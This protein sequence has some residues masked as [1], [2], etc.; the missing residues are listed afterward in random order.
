MQTETFPYD[1]ID[2]QERVRNA[3]DVPDDYISDL[4]DSIKRYGLL[5]PILI[6]QHNVLQD[7]WCRFTAWQRLAQED[8]A[9]YSNIP[10]YRRERLT[11][12]EY[13]EVE[14]ETNF[15]RRGFTWQE[16]IKAVKKIH[17]IRYLEAMATG[18]SWTAAMTGELLGG[19][20]KT[21]VNNCLNLAG[22]I[23]SDAY[24]ACD[25]I[26]DAVR[27]WLHQREDLAVAEQARRTQLKQVIVPAITA[28]G[29]VQ[30]QQPVDDLS[31]LMAGDPGELV[32]NL[33]SCLFQGDSVRDILP[34]WP[35]E[36]ID[37][38]ISDPP[39]GIDVDMMQQSSQALMDVSR[40]SDTHQVAEN[41]ALFKLMF[42]LFFRLLKPTGFCVLWADQMQWQNLY[43]TAVAAGFKVQ[44]WPHVWCKTSQ[45]KNQ[46]AYDNETKATEIAIVCRK[47]GAKLP[48][49]WQKNFTLC[50]GVDEKLSNPFAKPFDLWKDII[51]LVSLKGQT[52]LDPFAGEGTCPI[53]ALRLGRPILAIERDATH[54]P[55]MVES[56]KKFWKS[57]HPNV[58]FV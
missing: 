36:C 1:Q 2:I 8:P 13:F 26:T 14:L 4:C 15:R 38:I 9:K 55:Y 47:P 11:D 21:Y 45:C 5:Q 34:K 25:S 7:G 28:D 42:P 32:V 46:M 49:P 57:S 35:D 53:S 41:E 20:G 12:S 17:D 43:D 54:F 37:H 29:S 33:S 22:V 30:S 52:I 44:R 31:D 24:K 27:I 23:D 58:K 40:I 10:V 6:D 16:T 50:P 51:S 39:Y 3:K 56:V 19:Y 18:T 48:A